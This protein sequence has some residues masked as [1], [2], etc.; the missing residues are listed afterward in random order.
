MT[1]FMILADDKDVSLSEKPGRT[2]DIFSKLPSAK[3]KGCF[4]SSVHVRIIKMNGT[5][6]R[7]VHSN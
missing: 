6:L 1:N 2:S 5:Y 7:G 3:M 4:L